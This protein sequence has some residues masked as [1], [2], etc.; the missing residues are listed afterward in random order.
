MFK[1]LEI[2]DVLKSSS[3]K[4]SSEEDWFLVP[5]QL[6]WLSELWCCQNL[7]KLLPKSITIISQK[8]QWFVHGS[9]G[10]FMRTVS[11]SGVILQ[12]ASGLCFCGISGYSSAICCV[13]SPKFFPIWVSWS[14]CKPSLKN[15][16]VPRKYSVLSW[17][18]I[19]YKGHVHSDDTVRI[20]KQSGTSCIC[21]HV[22]SLKQTSQSSA[23][24]F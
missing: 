8:R 12:E 1:K 3:S 16:Y 7:E 11:A 9:F 24:L 4:S 13:L 18:I 22:P 15:M 19:K 20:S 5:S 10:F 6:S 2:W 23:C 21:T 14:H 17:N